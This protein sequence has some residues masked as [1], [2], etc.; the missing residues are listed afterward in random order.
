MIPFIGAMEAFRTIFS[1]VPL[2]VR[3]FVT[4]M[5]LLN[6]GVNFMIWLLSKFFS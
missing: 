4:T 3:L 2:S 1:L 5:V 6:L